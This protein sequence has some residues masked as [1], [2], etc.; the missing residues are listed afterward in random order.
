MN[1][2][3][4][5]MQTFIRCTQDALWDALTQADDMAR[6]HFACNTVQGNAAVGETTAFIRPD[7]SAIVEPGHNSAR[8]KV[9]NRHDV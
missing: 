1:K 2:P 8:P 6:Y 9:E 3:D 4:F 5:M 7:G